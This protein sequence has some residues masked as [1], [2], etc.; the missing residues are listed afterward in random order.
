MHDTGPFMKHEWKQFHSSLFF[1]Q[2]STLC[3][4]AMEIRSETAWYHMLVMLKIII[5][6]NELLR[7]MEN[8]TQAKYR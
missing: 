3:E 7:T 1:L 2:F 8:D 6:K 5:K 4:M